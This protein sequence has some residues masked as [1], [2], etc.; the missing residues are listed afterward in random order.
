MTTHKYWY[1]GKKSQVHLG[2]NFIV[3]L[4]KIKNSF[5]GIL[6]PRKLDYPNTM[7]WSQPSWGQ[8]LWPLEDVRAEVLG[9][10]PFF[11]SP[12]HLCHLRLFFFLPFICWWTFYLMSNLYKG[13]NIV[14][15]S[16]VYPLPRFHPQTLK[17]LPIQTELRHHLPGWNQTLNGWSH[18]LWGI[19]FIFIFNWRIVV[20][21]CRADLC[22]TTMWTRNQPEAYTSPLSWTALSAPTPGHPPGH[23]RAPAQPP[24]L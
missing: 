20:L 15:R 19:F 8:P 22:H 12:T 13:Y 14:Q 3:M 4:T 24:V 6:P 18:C 11:P 9:N 17:D 2:A 7:A 21:Q 10:L 5:W 1:K 23:H 16:P